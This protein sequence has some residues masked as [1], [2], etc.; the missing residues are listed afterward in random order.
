MNLIELEFKR[1][2]LKL[3]QKT[4]YYVSKF[5]CNFNLS[6]LILI[7]IIIVWK[8]ITKSPKISRKDFTFDFCN[9]IRFQLAKLI[10]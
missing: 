8:D 3:Y 7:N 2:F 4:N 6:Y 9:K 5:D 1:E 10:C